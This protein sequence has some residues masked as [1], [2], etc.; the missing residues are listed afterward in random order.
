MPVFAAEA[1]HHR[2]PAP[3]PMATLRAARAADAAAISGFLQ[4][5][6]AATRRLRFHGSCNP[7]SA[8][9]ALQLCQVDGVRHQAWLAW[10]GQGEDAV[11]VGEARFVCA[12]DADAGPA[13]A[14]LAITVADDWQGRGVADA[15]MRQVLAAA[16]MAGVHYLYGDVLDGNV[17]MQAFMRRHGFEADLFA[18]GEVLRMSR[19]PAAPRTAPGEVLAGAMLGALSALSALFAP[20]P[21]RARATGTVLHPR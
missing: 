17:R 10:V 12:A 6:S 5:L 19:A 2:R 4:G 7:R 9:L 15:L 14:E 3:T 1:L 18:R 21:R 13:A 8:A 11:V 20:G 16:A